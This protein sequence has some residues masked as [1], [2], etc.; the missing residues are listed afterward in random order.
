MVQNRPID[1]SVGELALV[2]FEFISPQPQIINWNFNPMLLSYSLG[3]QIKKVNGLE[4][5]S[6]IALPHPEKR[7]RVSLMKDEM[8]AAKPQNNNRKCRT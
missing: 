4:F 3:F 6:N 2:L 7:L 5:A 8:N 1:G